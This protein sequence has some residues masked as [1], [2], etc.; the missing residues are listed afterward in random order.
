MK[1]I[2]MNRDTKI[3]F[4]ITG[5]MTLCSYIV[6]PFLAV[7]FTNKGISVAKVGI[8]LGISSF[9]SAFAGIFSIY[10][11]KHIGIK[12]TLV[13]GMIILG[14]GY[15]LYS[16]V[17]NYTIILL[18]TIIQ[19]CGIGIINPLLKKVIAICNK[20]MENAAFRY[21]YIVLCIAIIIGPILGNLLSVFT[22][23]S[24]L[25]L[26]S[27]VCVLSCVFIKKIGIVSQGSVVVPENE[28]LYFKFLK[29]NK[30]N[31]KIFLFIVINI[32]IF[33]EF[34]V[35]ESVT[36]LALQVYIKNAEVVFSLLIIINSIMALIFQPFIIKLSEKVSNN[37]QIVIGS[38]A[39][40]LAYIVFSIAKGNM[41]LAILATTIFTLG[42]A[43]LIPLL[44]VLVSNISNDEQLTST[45]AISELKQLGF[46]IGPT[47]ATLLMQEFNVVVMYVA[48][49]ILCIL[50]MIFSLFL[51]L[52]KK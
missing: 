24:M 4:F 16:I 19:G 51:A 37:K 44:D 7:Y 45:Y 43:V 42:E 18:V 2:K 36:P 22:V 33:T 25:R 52:N 6:L 5:I 21:R 20:G 49:A 28:K 15:F 3:I 10:I 32:L 1:T 14:S 11:E 30:I 29:I 41:M 34:S 48:A 8:I 13:L 23:D 17:S 27:V 26:I 9:I 35:F 47:A 40:S 39:F 31:L 50:S 46:F 38:I 12:K